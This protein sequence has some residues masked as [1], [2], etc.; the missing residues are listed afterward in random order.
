MATST[1]TSSFYRSIISALWTEKT[2]MAMAYA[3]VEGLVL[4][5]IENPGDLYKYSMSEL[6]SIFEG[7]KKQPG[8]VV[9]GKY[10]QA[11]PLLLSAKSKKHIIVAAE[12]ARFYTQ[13]G[14]PM[15]PVNI[16]WKTL[17]I[18]ELQ[19]DALKELKNQDDPELPNLEKGSI[20]KCI[21]SFKLHCSNVVGVRNFPIFYFI[22]K[23]EANTSRPALA[24]NQPHSEEY[25]SVESE[26]VKLLSWDHPIF[27]NDN[28]NVFDRIERALIGTPYA[29]TIVRFC[30]ARD[31]NKAMAF[32]SVPYPSCRRHCC[33]HS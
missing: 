29:S 24:T 20:I 33:C 13:V 32:L 9:N 14:R 30:K 23:R 8:N 22:D 12:A 16:N 5:G 31:G 3:S 10:E 28:N 6:D 15:T 21:E 7:F 18:F 2:Q 4:E 19:W 26:L 17:A 25:G 27:K 11:M 1:V